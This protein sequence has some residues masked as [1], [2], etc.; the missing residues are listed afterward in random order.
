MIAEVN[1]YIQFNITNNHCL[2]SIDLEYWKMPSRRFYVAKKDEYEDMLRSKNR[3][4]L[5]LSLGRKKVRAE[6]IDLTT[7]DQYIL[8]RIEESAKKVLAKLR[9]LLEKLELSLY[10]LADGRRN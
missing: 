1:L 7:E 5:G 10:I 6:V 2:T 3:K 8:C 9:M 4:R